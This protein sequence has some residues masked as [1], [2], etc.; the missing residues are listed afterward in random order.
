MP[1]LHSK[2][3]KNYVFCCDSFTAT[4]YIGKKIVRTNF[5]MDDVRNNIM[6]Q[7][8]KFKN[9][10]MRAFWEN[11]R[12]V[13]SNG[14]KTTFE[15]PKVVYVKTRESWYL[16]NG[17]SD[18]RS[19]KTK[20]LCNRKYPPKPRKTHLRNHFCPLES[21]FLAI[22]T[23]KTRVFSNAP[24][25]RILKFGILNCFIHISATAKTDLVANFVELGHVETCSALQHFPWR[26]KYTCQSKTSK[27]III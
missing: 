23:Y 13:R 6:Y 4:S 5:R 17:I 18:H 8:K 21:G 22:A 3:S 20:T 10:P 2:N 27:S 24:N 14:R 12:F 1:Q 16:R 9:Q 26:K 15:W 7:Q 25:S 19:E 11:A